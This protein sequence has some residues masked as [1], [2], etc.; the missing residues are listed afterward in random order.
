MDE[1]EF[2]SS[3][4]I[5]KDLVSTWTEF[6]MDADIYSVKTTKWKNTRYY[7]D[8]IQRVADHFPEERSIYV[9]YQDIQYYND[10]LA[11]TLLSK[12]LS[13]IPNIEKAISELCPSDTPAEL[14]FRL[15]NI[16]FVTSLCKLDAPVH[17]MVS[18][19][20][21]IRRVKQKHKLCT[22]AIFRCNKCGYN[23][24][25][26]QNHRFLFR[27]PFKCVNEN[28]D[29]EASKTSF[30]FVSELSEFIDA[31][32]DILEDARE[33]VAG[34][35]PYQYPALFTN[36]LCQKVQ[37]GQRVII[38]G[39]L[40]TQQKLTKHGAKT[41]KFEPYIDVHSIENLDERYDIITLTNE[42]VKKIK[43]LSQKPNLFSLIKG[44]IAPFLFGLDD[45]KE[46][47]AL[48]LFAGVEKTGPRGEHLRGDIHILL[49]GDPGLGK[50]QLLKYIAMISPKAIYTSG[51]GSTEAGLTATAKQDQDGWYIEAGAL[52]MADRGICCIDEI[53]KMRDNDR[54]SIHEAME[55]QT[56]SVSKAAITAQLLSRCGI[57]AAANPKEGRFNYEESILEQ[58]SLSPVL[59]SRFGLIY[60]V[61]DEVDEK[62]DRHLA[63][64]ILE[65]AADLTLNMRDDDTQAIQDARDRLELPIPLDL[66]IKYIAYAKRYI[67]PALPKNCREM[68]IDYYVE[69]RQK[70]KN[71]RM[72]GE[73]YR[74]IALTPRQIEDIQRLAE[75]TARMRLSNKVNTSDVKH[76]IGVFKTCMD[77]VARDSQGRLDIDTI[78]VGNTAR[79][80]NTVSQV[81]NIVF[82]EQKNFEKG[83]PISAI[84]QYIKNN[85]LKI[86]EKDL[87]HAL[88]ILLTK[89]EIFH[90]TH[91]KDTVMTKGR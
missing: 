27:E 46:G 40:K 80:R 77:K 72:E 42:D 29:R 32:D 49:V 19:S 35:E 8:M 17:S 70:G 64:H 23:M 22:I 71:D 13:H 73:L 7:Y 90:P 14:V 83:A 25:V 18:L 5:D 63:E 85:D 58:I 28:C 45:I 75:A 51:K 66:F 53:D 15:T 47:L 43:E 21:M 24:R 37:P 38:H 4:P 39:I 81:L 84:E 48:F 74:R 26:P 1:A 11:L 41:R 34:P 6:L 89:G 86:D 76:A 36:D 31:E 54:D 78:M 44:N 91:R 16:P 52:P 88:E 60:P 12:P 56:V 59:I 3:V 82:A 10:E 57:L 61:Q 67:F 65:Y 30:D 9:N 79:S 69:E 50:S 87:H 2:G 68:I 20:V 62:I 33:S 55:Q